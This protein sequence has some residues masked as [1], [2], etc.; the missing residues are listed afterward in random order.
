MWWWP[1]AGF[2]VPPFLPLSPVPDRGTPGMWCTR[3]CRGR[4]Q[5]AVL[6]GDPP[7][8]FKMLIVVIPCAF[9]LFRAR[10]S[11]LLA[12]PHLDLDL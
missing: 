4:L 9:G 3:F 1:R 6:Q 8:L 2:R 12:K 5:P 7:F 10:F 11:P